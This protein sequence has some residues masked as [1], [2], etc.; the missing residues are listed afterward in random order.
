MNAILAAATNLR[1]RIIRA[2]SSAVAKRPLI[3]CGIPKTHS[4]LSL[5]LIADF[6]A[7]Y[8]MLLRV[9]ETAVGLCEHFV[10]SVRG[11]RSC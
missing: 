11:G 8:A 5:A 4:N 1:F 3:S 7:F 2:L 9:R 10:L 6:S